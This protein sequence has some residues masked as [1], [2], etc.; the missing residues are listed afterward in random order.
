[1]IVARQKH[2]ITQPM[3]FQHITISFSHKAV[4]NPR[5]RQAVFLRH[6]ASSAVIRCYFLSSLSATI[7]H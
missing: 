7:M 4:L 5:N 3:I 1:M 2:G 6:R